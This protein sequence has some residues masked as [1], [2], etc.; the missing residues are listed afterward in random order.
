MSLQ[1]SGTYPVVSHS[2]FHLYKNRSFNYTLT[3]YMYTLDVHESRNINMPFIRHIRLAFKVGRT[4][5]PAVYRDFKVSVSS[6]FRQR[7]FYV[8]MKTREQK[9]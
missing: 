9:K 7:E 2:L 1:V 4:G 6:F 8:P 3:L 5:H